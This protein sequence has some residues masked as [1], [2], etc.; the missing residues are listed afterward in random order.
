MINRI[1]KLIFALPIIVILIVTLLINARLYDTPEITIVNNDTLSIEVLAELR[2]LKNSLENHADEDMQQVF[3]EGFLFMNALYGLSWCNFI[4]GID[5]TSTYFKEGT[6]EI[7]K[8]YDKINSEHGRSSFD[9]DLPLPYGAF[10][11]GWS[12]YL[13][14]RKLDV[15][16][17]GTN[18]DE[19]KHFKDQC[20]QI[21]KA[22]Q[23]NPFPVSYRG[24]AWPADAMI[25]I[26]ALSLHDKMYTPIYTDII[27]AWIAH[28][29]SNLDHHMLI[30]HAVKAS[31]VE[32]I[33]DARGSSQ[34]LMLIFL[35]DVDESFAGQ[36]Y[37]IYKAEFPDVRFGLNGVREYPRDAPGSADVDSG[38][39]VFGMGS[40][41]TIVGIAT[42]YQF[43]ENRQG[44]EIR[45]TVEALGLSFNISARKTYL[46]GALPMA[47]AFVC[48]AH[49]QKK[50]FAVTTNSF[51]T[52]HLYSAAVVLVIIISLYFFLRD[53]KPSSG[54][55]LHIPW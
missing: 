15:E 13:L 46:F 52:F 35:R 11:V 42:M 29:K 36:Q 21:S 30:P 28:L 40:A 19:V 47:D 24:G 23:A 2:G 32:I 44:D 50:S 4:D 39:V 49:S 26:A 16:Q 38:P 34:S 9:P 51:A 53:E 54:R 7:Q 8:A 25:C 6:Q 10:Y 3:P 45:A 41:A 43:N 31:T 17:P 18:T 48:W 22:I 55:S 37:K 33:E 20:L 14:A 1:L 27:A 5:P 12:T